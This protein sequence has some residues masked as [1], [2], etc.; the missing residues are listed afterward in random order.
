MSE[1]V[2]VYQFNEYILSYDKSERNRS[3]LTISKT[4]NGNIYVMSELLDGS[5]DVVSMILDSLQTTVNY[6]KQENKIL[7]ENAEHNDKVVDKVNWE[8]QELK[9]QLEYLRSGE[10]YNQLRFE[11]DMLQ[12]VADNGKVSKE[13]KTFIDMTHR[14]TELLEVIE[15]VREYI[16]SKVI[17]NGEIID[18]LR[19]IEVK[20]LLQILDKVTN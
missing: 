5:A 13:D 14:N 6:C 1:E 10:Y 2:K 9:K 20:E 8:N 19:K 15:E 11:R 4:Q 16:N 18:Q 17:S 3:C 12:Y 7:R